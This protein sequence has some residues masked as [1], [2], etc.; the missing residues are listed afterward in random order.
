LRY[1]LLDPARI[2]EQISV[3]EEAIEARYRARQADISESAEREVRH[4]LIEVPAQAD[5]ERVEQARDQALVARERI[6][7]G[8]A[9]AQV[10]QALSDDPG[11]ANNGG[12]LGLIQPDDVVPRFADA[13]WALEPNTLS[14]PVRTDFGWHLI[15]VTDVRAQSLA[16]L[17]EL[18]ESLRD[19]IALERAEREVFEQGND[20]ETLAFEY[21]N[22]RSAAG[23]G[24][25]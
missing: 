18:R 11:S 13:A 19:E 5:A 24:R 8:E 16:P 2:A 4:I 9:F 1:V 22:D 21:P 12:M 20:L 17:A 25:A 15:E 14:E 6:E 23:G 10:A 3:S 7:A